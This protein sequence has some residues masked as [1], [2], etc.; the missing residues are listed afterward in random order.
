MTR[1][2]TVATERVE[3]GPTNLFALPLLVGP[4]SSSAFFSCSTS[5]ISVGAAT[6]GIDCDRGSRFRFASRT[7]VVLGCNS[8]SLTFTAGVL[9]VSPF[10]VSFCSVCLCARFRDASTTALAIAMAL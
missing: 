10:F 7:T 2:T 3:L 5:F 1:G 6:A 4:R 8:A 9:F